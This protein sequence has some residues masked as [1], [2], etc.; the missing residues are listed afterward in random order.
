MKRLFAGEHILFYD[1]FS[2]LDILKMK[3]YQIYQSHTFHDLNKEMATYINYFLFNPNMYV[4]KVFNIFFLM[5]FSFL[6]KCS[7]TV[8]NSNGFID[9]TKKAK[10]ENHLTRTFVDSNEYKTIEKPVKNI[11]PNTRIKTSPY[12]IEADVTSTKEINVNHARDKKSSGQ[13]LIKAKPKQTSENITDNNQTVG[14]LAVDIGNNPMIENANTNFLVNS[15]ASTQSSHND[16]L[17]KQLADN[18]EI[19]IC[20]SS[21][22]HITGP[23]ASTKPADS[24]TPTEISDNNKMVHGHSIV[25]MQCKSMITKPIKD[26]S[27]NNE[28]DSRSPYHIGYNS[29]DDTIPQYLPSMQQGNGSTEMESEINQSELRSSDIFER[30]QIT[31]HSEENPLRRICQT[32]KDVIDESHEQTIA[33]IKETTYIMNKSKKHSMNISAPDENTISLDGSKTQANNIF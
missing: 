26:K 11:I 6:I 16:L 7:N 12:N 19:G 5:Y 1:R 2:Y 21:L 4:K 22:N 15:K 9:K 25:N 24:D 8:P 23:I 13:P 14:C 30:E 33:Q 28:T 18:D 32:G 17:I 31:N 10:R 20:H 3:I 27:V 29:T